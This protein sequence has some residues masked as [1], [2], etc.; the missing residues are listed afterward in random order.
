MEGLKILHL[1]KRSIHYL[2][3]KEIKCTGL[4]TNS[5]T[6]YEEND[7]SIFGT[8]IMTLSIAYFFRSLETRDLFFH[9]AFVVIV[10]I[11]K[12]GQLLNWNS[13]Y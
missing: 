9:A 5:G 3:L 7:R 12:L 1:R 8:R 2:P 4:C 6:F 11:S 13:L 10:M